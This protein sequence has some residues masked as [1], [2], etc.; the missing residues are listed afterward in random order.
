MQGPDWVTGQRRSH[1]YQLPA[2]YPVRGG[3]LEEGGDFIP[4]PVLHK[5]AGYAKSTT[6]H[7]TAADISQAAGREQPPLLRSPPPPWL[8]LSLFK[9]LLPLLLPLIFPI[10]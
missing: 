5:H 9:I 2:V 10:S 7:V 1:V 8:I 6:P 3:F 4:L